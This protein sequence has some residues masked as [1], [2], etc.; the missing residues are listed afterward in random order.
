MAP[1]RVLGVIFFPPLFPETDI[2]RRECKDLW[3]GVNPV[4]T[5]GSCSVHPRETSGRA[6]TSLGPKGHQEGGQLVGGQGPPAG[7]G[8]SAWQTQGNE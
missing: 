5:G 1:R 3:L 8:T 4:L 7:T 2:K 6:G